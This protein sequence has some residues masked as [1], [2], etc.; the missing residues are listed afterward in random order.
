MIG[1]TCPVCDTIH[2]ATAVV[3]VDRFNPNGPTGY[4]AV[5]P[6]RA[7]REEAMADACAIRAARRKE[8]P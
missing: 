5:A 4:Q 6:I 1:P 2:E 8:K 3:V 7:T